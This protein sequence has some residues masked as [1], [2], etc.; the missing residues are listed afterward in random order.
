ML[1]H[2]QAG[3][4]LLG[5]KLALPVFSVLEELNVSLQ[6]R[7]ATIS[8]M[9]QAVNNVHGYLTQLRS[10][11]QFREILTSANVQI[12]ELDLE[13]LILPRRRRPPARFT[14]PAEAYV[15]TTV[16][17][18]YRQAFFSFIDAAK[19]QLSERFDANVQP[20]SVDRFHLSLLLRSVDVLAV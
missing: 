15:A 13:P 19:T 16:E 8:G 17:E 1:A 10:D 6:A 2:F 4:L 20:R 12:A 7:N 5:L 11:E 18:Y 14:G 3:Q 9:L